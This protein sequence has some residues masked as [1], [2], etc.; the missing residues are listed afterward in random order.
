MLNAN[1]A[2]KSH[3]TL[4]ESSLLI[5]LTSPQF[6]LLLELQK[7]FSFNRTHDWSSTRYGYTVVTVWY[8]PYHP[9]TVL[10]GNSVCLIVGF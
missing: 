3:M 6:F 7:Y 8:D 1:F 4:D 10:L 2:L 9:E 5:P